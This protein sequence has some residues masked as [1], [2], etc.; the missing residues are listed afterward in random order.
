MT[1]M[2]VKI[3]LAIFFARIIVRRNHFVLVYI[4]VG[5]NVLSSISAFFYCF[6]RCGPSLDEYAINQLMDRC[7]PRAI[8]LFMAYQ[9]GTSRRE[10]IMCTSTDDKR[11]S[12]L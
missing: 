1:V 4:T 12:G 6:F 3:S 7:T 5:V 9:Q 8:D 2:I 11:H 10:Y